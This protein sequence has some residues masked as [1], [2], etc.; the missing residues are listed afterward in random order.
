MIFSSTHQHASADAGQLRL[1]HEGQ[2]KQPL[3]V[4]RVLRKKQAK[5]NSD[6]AIRASSGPCLRF[7][8]DATIFSTCFTP[9]ARVALYVPHSITDFK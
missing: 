7:R 4:D 1:A 3:L 9:L 5:S 8:G 6:D 2:L